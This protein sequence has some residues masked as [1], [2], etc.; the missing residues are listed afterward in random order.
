MVPVLVFLQAGQSNIVG[1]HVQMPMI[2]QVQVD[3]CEDCRDEMLAIIL[4]KGT[5]RMDELKKWLAPSTVM[6]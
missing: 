4:N 5:V 2:V 1:Q 6:A 3:L